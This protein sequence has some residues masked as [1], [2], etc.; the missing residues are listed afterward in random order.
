MRA[1]LVGYASPAYC[2]KLI[3]SDSLGELGIS[4]DTELKDFVAH[5]FFVVKEGGRLNPRYRVCT[6]E[7]K[8]SSTFV[9]CDAMMHDSV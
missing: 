5:P 7:C 2:C 9:F 3:P 1:L 4:D 8:R 6:V